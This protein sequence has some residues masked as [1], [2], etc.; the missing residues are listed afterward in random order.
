MRN[1]SFQQNYVP[2][3]MLTFKLLQEVYLGK[4]S[5][6]H[7]WWQ[8]LPQTFSTGLYL[9][10]VERK[11]VECMAGDFLSTHEL[12]YKA[13]VG[14]MRRM[15]QAQE[16]QPII[17]NG[18]Y[19]WLRETQDMQ[20]EDGENLFESLVKW[21]FTVVFTRSW[22]SPDR[23]H[24]NIIPIGDLANHDSQQANLQPLF[25]PIDGA[26]QF[27]LMEDMTENISTALPGKLF[28]SYGSGS[29]P[30][31]YLVLFGFCDTSSPYVD[32]HINFLDDGHD[33]V[34][35]AT[36][37][38]INNEWPHCVLDQSQ[39]VISTS[40]GAV[41]EEVWIAFLYKVLQ[42]KDPSALAEVRD[43]FQDATTAEGD[44]MVEILWEMYEME[45][46][47]EIQKH[48]ERLLQTTFAPIILTEQDLL[49]HPNLDMIVKYNLF[50][51]DC[52]IKALK[53]LSILLDPA[54][55]MEDMSASEAST[56]F[57]SQYSANSSA[58]TVAASSSVAPNGSS[59]SS[60]SMDAYEEALR[61][62]SG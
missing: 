21:A 18:F 1:T 39:M 26:F 2:E 9:D 30:A 16:Q 6:W 35:D 29:M 59:D 28:L 33:Q 14:L 51:R 47:T 60:Q 7:A 31:R 53:H 8:S 24:A 41:S 13:F 4:N 45:I 22:R 12:Q 10:D 19:L 17:P 32:A 57:S 54:R 56:A 48:F 3:F 42:E 40:S 38:Q 37:N 50:M 46:G 25:R 44:Q 36:G 34:L 11:F 23:R 52:L 43:S 62:S 5:R 20:D 55:S 15:M 49:D 61:K 58:D 27:Y